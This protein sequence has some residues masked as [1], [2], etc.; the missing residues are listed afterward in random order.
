[1]DYVPAFSPREIPANI[2]AAG[3]IKILVGLCL[4]IRHKLPPPPSN[5]WVGFLSAKHLCSHVPLRSGGPEY[6]NDKNATCETLT[7][8]VS[9]VICSHWSGN[10][11][12]YAIFGTYKKLNMIEIDK[13]IVQHGHDLL[14]QP[15]WSNCLLH[16]KCINRYILGFS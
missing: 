2:R 3:E 6:T 12:T 13:S 16:L 8:N 14:L 4:C 10:G 1:M 7:N 11:Y 5:F 9:I 15:K